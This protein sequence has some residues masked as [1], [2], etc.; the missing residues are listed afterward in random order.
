MLLLYSDSFSIQTHKIK[1]KK[2]QKN[3]SP[4]R[5]KVKVGKALCYYFNNMLQCDRLWPISMLVIV[6]SSF[7]A[8]Y[9]GLDFWLCNV[10]LCTLIYTTAEC[11][12]AFII[13]ISS[14]HS[15]MPCTTVVVARD[16]NT[17]EP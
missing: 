1:K 16:K 13:I 4:T 12:K 15:K 14:N 3:N 9:F 5:T 7:E 17:M 11:P 8:A 10:L 6:Y 2:Q